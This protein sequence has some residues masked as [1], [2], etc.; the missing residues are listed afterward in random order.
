[1]N[2]NETIEITPEML[3]AGV[4]ALRNEPLLDCSYGQAVNLAEDVIR[5]ALAAWRERK[6][7]ERDE[8][9]KAAH[10]IPRT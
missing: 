9:E 10:D 8:K 5:R 3:A 7:R 2:K 1:M 4:E 6:A